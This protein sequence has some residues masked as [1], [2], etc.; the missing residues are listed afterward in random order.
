MEEFKW[1]IVGFVLLFMIWYANGGAKKVH[2]NPFIEA[3][4]EV[5]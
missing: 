2:T 3:P 1:F 4:Q 5:R